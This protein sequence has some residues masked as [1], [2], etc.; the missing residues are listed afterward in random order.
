MRERSFRGVA[1]VW[2]A[3]LMIGWVGA[4]PAQPEAGDV[5]VAATIGAFSYTDLDVEGVSAELTEVGLG[6]SGDLRVAYVPTELVEVGLT[7]GLEYA[8]LEI[9]GFSGEDALSWTVGPYADLNIPVNEDRTIVLSPGFGVA[10][11]RFEGAGAEVDG[12]EIR[13]TGMLKWFVAESASLDIGLEFSYLIGQ[14]DDGFASADAD[15]FTIGPRVGISIW[16]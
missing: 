11:S 9:G 7:A 6:P 1:G 16:P 10:Y 5:R 3:V 13:L 2:T 12:V 15:G 4:A 14:A 8:D